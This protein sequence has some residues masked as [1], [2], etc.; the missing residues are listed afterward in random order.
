MFL[1]SLRVLQ[2]QTRGDLYAINE[3]TFFIDGFNYDGLGVCK[4]NNDISLLLRLAW[5]SSYSRERVCVSH[6]TNGRSTWWWN[7]HKLESNVRNKCTG[8]LVIIDVP[9]SNLSISDIQTFTIWCK[10]FQV[11]FATLNLPTDVKIPPV[12]GKNVFVCISLLLCIVI[13]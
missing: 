3:K 2:H 10:Q 13:V 7:Y 1:G 8:N 5:C 12:V 4:C 6:W 11:F 9:T